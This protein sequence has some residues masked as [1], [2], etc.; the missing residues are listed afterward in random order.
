MVTYLMWSRSVNLLRAPCCLARHSPLAC[1]SPSE[2]EPFTTPTHRRRLA[3]ITSSNAGLA[4][5]ICSGLAFSII[6]SRFFIAGLYRFKLDV[7]DWLSVFGVAGVSARLV[8][9]HYLLMDGM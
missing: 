2:P 5:W 8:V 7:A 9:D 6:L 3:M 1:R 4:T